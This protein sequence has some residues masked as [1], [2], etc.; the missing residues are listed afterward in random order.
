[1]P[2]SGYFP[3]KVAQE[4]LIKTAD[5]VAVALC[6]VALGVPLNGTVEVAGPE[7]FRLDELVRQGLSARHDPREVLSDSQARY[8]GALL[9]ERT[10]V[11][12]AGAWLGEVHFKEWLGQP[13]LP[14]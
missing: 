11:P 10:L 9:T 1:M 4:K 3:A 6:R 7:Q 14:R 8:S 13:A 12:G 2:D 5:D